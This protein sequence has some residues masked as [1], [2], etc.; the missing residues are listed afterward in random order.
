MG[1]WL[2]FYKNNITYFY[3]DESLLILYQYKGQHRK[4]L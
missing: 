3:V 2:L 1:G 4:N